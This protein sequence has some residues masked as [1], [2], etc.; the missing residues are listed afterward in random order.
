MDNSASSSSRSASPEPTVSTNRKR[1]Q[2][3]DVTLKTDLDSS[4][5]SES[6]AEEFD[7]RLKTT[8]EPGEP[9]LSHAERRRRKREEKIAE[10]LKEED[11]GHP[12]KKRKLRDGTTKTIEATSHSTT[13][14]QNSVWVG[15]LSY[16]TQ[17]DSLRT[18]FKAAGEITRIHM[19]TKT[20]TRP[21]MKS[22]N[23]GC[24]LLPL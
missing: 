4:A 12:H 5:A 8:Q 22:E 21:G 10:K 24:V 17:Y 16:K 15:N 14:R 7:D 18:F 23:R 3:E 20:L 6:E 2:K 13:K 9:V 19:P 1:K 11:G